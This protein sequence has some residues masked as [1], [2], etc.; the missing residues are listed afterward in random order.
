MEGRKWGTN[1]KGDKAKIYERKIKKSVK[2]EKKE[3]GR[4]GR[5][6]VKKEKKEKGRKGRK[7]V[8][9]EEKWYETPSSS[10]MF[11]C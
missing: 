4:K 7:N 6:N 11:A 8:K 3:K 9:K 10:G 1:E 2:K 5:K